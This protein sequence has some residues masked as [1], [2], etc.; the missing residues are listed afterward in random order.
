MKSD[1][2]YCFPE[3]WILC[4]VTSVGS[5]LSPHL[6]DNRH[7]KPIFLFTLPMTP[8]V[9]FYKVTFI[10]LSPNSVEIKSP[11]Y[12]YTVYTIHS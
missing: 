8:V 10:F 2:R 11:D 5:V 7:Q 12:E 4:K 9:N 3:T 1:Y 6:L